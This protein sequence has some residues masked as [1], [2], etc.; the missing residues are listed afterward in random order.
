M[1]Y[2]KILVVKYFQ[3]KLQIDMPVKVLK[4]NPA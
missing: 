2:T 4:R 3:L 1:F